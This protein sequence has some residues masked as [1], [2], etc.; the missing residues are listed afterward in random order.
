VFLTAFLD[1][2]RRQTLHPGYFERGSRAV[3]NAAAAFHP[4]RSILQVGCGAGFLLQ[5]A[6]DELKL[7]DLVGVDAFAYL[8][9][10]SRLPAS[11][12]VQ[13]DLASGHFRLQ[14]R[15]DMVASIEIGQFIAESQAED[16]V[17]SLTTHGSAVLF[18]AAVPGQEQRRGEINP[19]Y[20]EYWQQKFSQRGYSMLDFFRPFH[21]T[22][23]G[24][25]AWACQN[26]V[27]FYDPAACDLAAAFEAQPQPRPAFKSIVHPV[28]YERLLER[29]VRAEK[30]VAQLRASA[31]VPYM[32]LKYLDDALFSGDEVQ[33]KA[34]T[35]LIQRQQLQDV[36][37]YTAVSALCTANDLLCAAAHFAELNI[38]RPDPTRAD[39]ALRARSAEAIGEFETL[40]E[41]LDRLHGADPVDERRLLL[42]LRL[43]KL[44]YVEAAMARPEIGSKLTRLLPLIEASRRTP[45]P[46]APPVPIF[47]VNLPSDRYRRLR[48]ERCLAL[49]KLE[50]EFWRGHKPH[51][52]PED[53]HR[54]FSRKLDV[55]VDGSFGN[56][57]TQY[58][59]WKEVQDRG[60]D[61]ALCL[62]DDSLLV[63]DPAQV[64]RRLNLPP[65]W[66]IIFANPRMDLT[67]TADPTTPDFSLTPFTEAFARLSHAY[68]G[69]R[70]FGADCYFLSASG[71]RKLVHLAETEGFHSVG[72]DW[73]LQ[74]HCVPAGELEGFSPASHVYGELSRRHSNSERHSPLLLNGYVLSPSLV[75]TDA[76]GVSRSLR[77]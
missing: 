21:F 51:E 23:G 58:L 25:P 65:G 63:T 10:G 73:W 52:I 60:L 3:L 67:R 70:G 7:T 26:V 12:Y 44:D 64:L 56:Q 43:R 22:R 2:F 75:S 35:A 16:F 39:R 50:A 8:E 72:T 49:L 48:S 5:T 54:L 55:T 69:S 53:G 76:M 28:Y 9:E 34:L 4:I 6:R 71:A 32:R 42:A 18:S 61:L 20:L 47:I 24:L 36:S 1:N 41:L 31:A 59:L 17:Q 19:Q 14:R 27:M 68:P 30:T 62:E 74:S 40:W 37:D 46:C 33:A 38:R 15:F 29:T 45:D 11:C 77:I 57:Y 13:V 66:D